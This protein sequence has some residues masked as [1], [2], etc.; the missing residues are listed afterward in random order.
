MRS[1]GHDKPHY[2]SVCAVDS[3]FLH[4]LG[5][6]VQ[7]RQC[8]I[9]VA[10]HATLM[11]ERGICHHPPLA[12]LADN[13]VG[14]HTNI[15]EEHLVKFGLSVIVIKGRT[16]YRVSIENNIADALMLGRIGS[17]RTSKNHIRLRRRAGPYFW[18]L[19]TK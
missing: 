11:G 18:P 8:R 13:L 4:N 3:F 12:A 1:D 14:G 17:V 2:P 10:Q 6:R 9:G 15:G 5:N 19:T 16:S 7:A